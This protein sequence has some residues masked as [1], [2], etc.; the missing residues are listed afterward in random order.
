MKQILVYGDSVAWGLIPGSK[1]DRY[2]RNIR[3]PGVLQHQ[4]GQQY[5]VIEECLCARTIDSDDARPGFEGRNGLSLISP[6]IDSHYPLD[7]III[8]LGLNELKSIY[9]WS[10][11]E[12]AKKMEG[13]IDIVQNRK[14]NFHEVSTPILLIGPHIVYDTGVWGTLWVGAEEKSQQITVLFSEVAAKKK[15]HFLETA[16]FIEAG[17]DGVHL[18]EANQEKLAVKVTELVNNIM[19]V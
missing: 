19:K 6:L 3:W 17:D 11:T 18:N 10:I 2:P 12:I 8:A 14:P 5:N 9:T 13:F 7:L 1:F 16:S 15:I 4:L